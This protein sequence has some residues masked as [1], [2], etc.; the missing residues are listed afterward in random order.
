MGEKHIALVPLVPQLHLASPYSCS[1]CG[2][3]VDVLRL[4][5]PPVHRHRYVGHRDQAAVRGAQAEVL[6]TQEINVV[7]VNKAITKLQHAQSPG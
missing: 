4:I 6:G 5:F 1:F 7:A 2:F 3:A